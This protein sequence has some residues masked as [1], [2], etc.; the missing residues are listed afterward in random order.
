MQG[1]PDSSVGKEV[2]CK[3]FQIEG[4][5]QTLPRFPKK[6]EKPRDFPGGPVVKT[7]G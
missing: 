2:L 4:K 1:F 5:E 3:L 6:A 7:R